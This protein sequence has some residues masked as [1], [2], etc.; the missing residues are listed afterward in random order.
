[1]VI[2]IKFLNIELFRDIELYDGILIKDG[3]LRILMM[4][5]YLIYLLL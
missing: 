5:N 3:Y 1:M 4:I 2:K